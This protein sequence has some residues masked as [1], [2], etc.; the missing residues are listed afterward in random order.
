MSLK[1]RCNNEEIYEKT[2]DKIARDIVDYDFSGVDPDDT[3]E[4]CY[5]LAVDLYDA[6]E[7]EAD[8]I[9]RIIMDKYVQLIDG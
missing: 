3:D 2:L 6:S 5:N 4:A 7:D 8:K 9:V 1:E